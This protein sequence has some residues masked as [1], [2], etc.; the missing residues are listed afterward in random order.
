MR[1]SWL[2]DG[3]FECFLTELSWPWCF[4]LFA[5]PRWWPLARFSVRSI[6]LDMAYA[7]LYVHLCSF[8]MFQWQPQLYKRFQLDY[9][10]WQAQKFC[11]CWS[12]HNP[13]SRFVWHLNFEIYC[14][15]VLTIC[16]VSFYRNLSTASN[17]LEKLNLLF[18]IDYAILS[19]HSKCPLNVF[20]S[21][22][23]F[24]AAPLI[25]CRSTHLWN[26]LFAFSIELD[27]VFIYCQLF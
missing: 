2:R 9:T 22:K 19:S 23:F 25:N 6:C 17:L 14:H 1:T 18:Q 12:W 27:F 5:G 24:S 26:S 15:T 20:H 21:V 7:C 8:E 4:F 11:Y 16:F 3:L 10:F 13:N